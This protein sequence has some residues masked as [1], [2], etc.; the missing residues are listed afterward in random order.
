[1]HPLHVNLD[2]YVVL[3][4]GLLAGMTTEKETA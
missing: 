3:V 1:M 4:E 2:L